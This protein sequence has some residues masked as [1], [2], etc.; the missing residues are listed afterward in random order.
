MSI[1]VIAVLETTPDQVW[2]VIGQAD[3]V[4]WVAGVESCSMEDGIRTFSMQGA[5]LLREK[6]ITCDEERY[7]L[8]Y[9]VVESTPPLDAHRASMQL[10]P[11]P[12]GTELTWT[13]DVQPE[14]VEPFIQAGMEGS[15]AGLRQVL[16]L[17]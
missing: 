9:G 13:T 17:T 16:G 11:H 12:D 4:D 7:L 14:Q 8:E 2:R 15:L 1:S 5:G 3:R 6:I 10:R